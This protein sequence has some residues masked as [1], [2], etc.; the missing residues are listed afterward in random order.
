M[1]PMHTPTSAEAWLEWFAVEKQAACRAYL[2]TRYALNALDA[3]ALINAA[4]VQIW[5]FWAR[6]A[7]P[8]AYVWQTLR[9]AVARQGQGHRRAQQQLAAYAQQQRLQAQGAT[10]TTAQVATVLARVAPRQR[11]LLT[12]Y[13]QGVDDAQVAA[14]LGTTPQAIRVA[15]H[16]AYQALRIQMC[17]A[18]KNIVRGPNFI[19]PPTPL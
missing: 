17:H 19:P 15:R 16:G 5:R 12:W 9:H 8:L 7:N 18:G 2:C 11:C 14:W 3:E 4:L 1:H 10:R 13:A 6:I